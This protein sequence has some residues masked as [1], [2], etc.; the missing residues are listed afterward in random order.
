MA[1]G[2]RLTRDTVF[3][4]G[5]R[6]EVVFT[7]PAAGRLTAVGRYRG[8]VLLKNSCAYDTARYRWYRSIPDT[9][10]R[11]RPNPNCNIWHLCRKIYKSRLL[12]VA[13]NINGQKHSMRLAC[14]VHTRM[15]SLV[16][17]MVLSKEC[18]LFHKSCN[19]HT[20][21]A[22]IIIMCNFYILPYRS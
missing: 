20:V 18:R 12:V 8:Q 9:R 6:A 2:R 17:G 15:A 16:Y 4:T 3:T 7:T 11:Y 14:G 21:T 13:H 1:A 22:A 19:K 5:R 10:Y